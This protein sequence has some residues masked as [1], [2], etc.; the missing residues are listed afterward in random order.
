LNQHFLL[1]KKVLPKV[2]ELF[3]ILYQCSDGLSTEKPVIPPIKKQ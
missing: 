1:H 2:Q 3:F